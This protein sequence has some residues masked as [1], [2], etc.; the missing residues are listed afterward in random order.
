ME[1]MSNR[2]YHADFLHDQFPRRLRSQNGE[3]PL[4]NL[5]TPRECSDRHELIATY[6]EQPFNKSDLEDFANGDNENSDHD[7]PGPHQ[8]ESYWLD[9]FQDDNGH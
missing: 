2:L 6:V 7:V 5:I 4:D 3:Q 1:S 9:R 8:V